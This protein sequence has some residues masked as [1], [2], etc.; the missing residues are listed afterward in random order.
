MNS[1][2]NLLRAFS[3]YVKERHAG[4][5]YRYAGYTGLA[6]SLLIKVKDT[7]NRVAI[8]PWLRQRPVGLADIRRSDKRYSSFRRQE[9]DIHVHLA[10]SFRHNAIRY[11]RSSDASSLIAYD[12][13]QRAVGI[14][15][16]NNLPKAF[17]DAFLAFCGENVLSA[18]Y[19]FTGT[20]A[21]KGFKGDVAQA[22]RVSTRA[23]NPSLFLSYSWDSDSHRHW[24]LKLAADLIRSGVQV[25]ID[26]WDLQEYDD[27]LNHFMETG[28]RESDYVV[29]VCTPEY[30]KRANDR[31]GGVGVESTIITGEF[32][33]RSKA[34]KFLPI[35]RNAEGGHQSCLPSYLKSRYATDFTT[36]SVYQVKF[37]ELLRRLFRQ[38]RYRKPELGPI[39][40]FG[41]EDV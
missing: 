8:R 39:P 3:D 15:A 41:S 20:L 1:P 30:R 9:P 35:L 22:D 38:P 17:L 19:D 11:A 16:S 25:L 12:P 36:D 10:T 29:L 34:R 21:H 32:Y 2:E 4:T 7:D 14:I 37:E 40:Q 27:D 26:E 13:K 24:V 33:D 5:L 23:R 31:K 6:G 18:T 28:I